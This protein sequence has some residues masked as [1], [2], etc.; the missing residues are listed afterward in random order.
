MLKVC[1]FQDSTIILHFTYFLKTVIISL[2]ERQLLCN[3]SGFDLVKENSNHSVPI[4]NESF[5]FQLEIESAPNGS[6]NQTDWSRTVYIVLL[7]S[8]FC[9][10]FFFKL[11]FDQVLLYNKNREESP[12]STWWRAGLLHP[13]ERVQIPVTSF[14]AFNLGK[15][16]NPLKLPSM[17]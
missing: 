16:T 11:L 12:Y 10:V 3:F 13:R 8:Y 17:C 7:Y 15:G 6:A 5:V 14:W 9:V 1:R 2:T 4:F